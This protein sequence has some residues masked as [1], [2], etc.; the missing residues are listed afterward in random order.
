MRNKWSS[1][2]PFVSKRTLRIHHCL[3]FRNIGAFFIF[4]PSGLHHIELPRTEKQKFK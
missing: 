2:R 3:D 4:V 1:R